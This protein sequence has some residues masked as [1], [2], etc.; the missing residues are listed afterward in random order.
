MNPTS[1]QLRAAL[2]GDFDKEVGKGLKRVEGA[3]QGA[4][5]EYGGDLQGKW[6]RD[7]EASRL[8]NGARAAKT[9]R[10]ARYKN[11]GLNPATLVYTTWPKVM[12]AFERGGTIRAPAG[13]MFIMP[14]PEVW[15]GGRVRQASR[16]AGAGWSG[17]HE[18]Q[19]A[20]A[21]FG[22]LRFVPPISGRPGMLVAEAI[23]SEKTGR[24]RRDRRKDR[25]TARGEGVRFAKGATTVVVFFLTREF[26]QPR[27][28][29]GNVIRARA[30]RDAPESINRLFIRNMERGDAPLALPAPEA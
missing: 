8:A 3:L 16:S 7:V 2:T 28:L 4:F 6:R 29:R 20:K 25:D 13:K 10:L 30:E 15:P 24:F 23:Y 14:N 12:A 21:R 9:I 18:L 22:D 11:K 1:L 5:F 27:L 26:R 17:S 19:A